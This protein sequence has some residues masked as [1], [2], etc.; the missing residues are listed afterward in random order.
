MGNQRVSFSDANGDGSIDVNTEVLQTTAYYPFGMQM[1]GSWSQNA[2][3]KHRYLFGGKE[4]QDDF[5][6]NTYDYITRQYDPAIGRFWQIDNLAENFTSW[7]PFSFSFNNPI[8]F[9][10]PDGQAPE[11]IIIG[12]KSEEEQYQV[13]SQLRQLTNDE[14]A[15]QGGKVVITSQGTANQGKDLAE[16]TQLIADLINDDNTTTVTLDAERG[17]GAFAVN[18]ET[19]QELKTEAQPNTEYDSN[20]YIK[21]TNPQ[22]V[23]A[24]RTRGLE[25][26][27][28]I[29]LGHELEHARDHVTGAST[30]Q[31]FP[32]TFDF[33][34][35]QGSG[36]FTNKFSFR[37]YKTR[38]FENKLRSEQGLKPRALPI[39][40]L[41]I[42]LLP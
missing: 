3:P 29:S 6:L 10:D 28:F 34:K 33:D 26:G 24:D 22:T 40:I 38:V 16:G 23:N 19:N 36:G 8:R 11:D 42:K 1:E 18:P 35:N 39:P 32:L 21:G 37:E 13:L 25:G 30:V 27:S 14:L 4:L 20:V 12:N 31:K 5:G 41:N 9:I 17:N 15:I 7:S 2:S